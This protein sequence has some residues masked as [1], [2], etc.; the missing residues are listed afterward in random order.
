MGFYGDQILPRF[1]NI[2]MSRGDITELRARV[3]S[4]LTGEVLE[5]GFG[6]GLNVPHYPPTLTRVWAVDPATVG[7]R[8]GARRVAAS[9]VPVEFIG[10]DAQ[11]IPLPDESVDHVLTTWTLCT[12]PDVGQALA[13]VRRVLRPGGVLH[14]V[15]H[16]RSPDPKVARFQDRINSMHGRLFGGCQLNRPIDHIVTGAGLELA[17]LKTYYRPGPAFDGYTFEGAAAKPLSPSG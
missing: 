14:F 5:I 10:L 12:I 11:T 7:R 15:E 8:L 4:H 6:S 16:G 13:E 9:P 3:A 17:Q 1:L 2:I